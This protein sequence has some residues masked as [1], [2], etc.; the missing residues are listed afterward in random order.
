MFIE[1]ANHII[2]KLKYEKNWAALRIDFI[3]IVR[4][5]VQIPG[6][7]WYNEGLMSQSILG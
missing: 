6:K 3:V 4:I 5:F 2:I 7:L 1:V